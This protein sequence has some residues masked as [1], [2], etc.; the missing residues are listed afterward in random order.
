LGVF[1]ES[2]LEKVLNSPRSHEEGG[3]PALP[4]MEKRLFALLTQGPKAKFQL[5][6]ILYGNSQDILAAESSVKNLISRVRSKLQGAII[7]DG[8]VYKRVS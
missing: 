1:V 6:E 4:P 2:A 7:H 3:N 5:I 8:K